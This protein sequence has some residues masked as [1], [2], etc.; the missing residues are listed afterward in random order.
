MQ[1]H[2]VTIN[3]NEP[4]I[5]TITVDTPDNHT[6]PDIEDL[7]IEQFEEQYPEAIDLEILEVKENIN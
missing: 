2:E 3:Y 4:R 5:A 1:T 7:A 6:I